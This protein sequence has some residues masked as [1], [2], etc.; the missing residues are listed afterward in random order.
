M[1]INRTKT[2]DRKDSTERMK[3]ARRQMGKYI[4]GLVVTEQEVSTRAKGN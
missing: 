4:I 1:Q 3:R 2:K